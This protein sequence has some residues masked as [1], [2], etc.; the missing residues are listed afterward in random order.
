MHVSS[1]AGRLVEAACRGSVFLW[2]LG[3]CNSRGSCDVSWGFKENPTSLW[4][5]SEGHIM[6]T[7]QLV[8]ATQLSL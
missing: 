3:Y 2:F 6:T 7:G 8:L 5:S 1:T 4:A